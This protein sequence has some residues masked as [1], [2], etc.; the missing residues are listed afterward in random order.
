MKAQ[1]R[2]CRSFKELREEDYM[3]EVGGTGS[4]AGD[5]LDV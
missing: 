4:E 5:E 2:R 1:L 3:E